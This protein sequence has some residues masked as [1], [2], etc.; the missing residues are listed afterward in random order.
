MPWARDGSGLLVFRH[1]GRT[2]AQVCANAHMVPGT[3]A[4]KRLDRVDGPAQ[5]ARG[6]WGP[7]A[8]RRRKR[9]G[10]YRWKPF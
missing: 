5:M 6:W 1:R 8:R 10:W 7:A 2:V 4:L 3:R 9:A